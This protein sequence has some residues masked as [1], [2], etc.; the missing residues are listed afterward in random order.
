MSTVVEAIEASNSKKG[1]RPS[2]KPSEAT[3][4]IVVLMFGAGITEGLIAEALSI[5]IK[6]LIK[7]YK[8]ELKCA[9][10]RFMAQVA[11]SMFERSKGKDGT[12]QR[13]GEFLLQTRFGW[14][15]YAPPPAPPK[16]PA[17]GK[18]ELLEDAAQVGNEPDEW[19]RLLQ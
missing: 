19:A 11:V 2:H 1:G 9:Q 13:A 6:T 3:R 16:E 17:K 18:K 14:S 15:K 8:K 12:A 4:N 10:A 7:H 5:S